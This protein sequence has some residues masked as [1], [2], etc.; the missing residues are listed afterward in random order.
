MEFSTKDR[1]IDR[2]SL[3]CVCCVMDWCLVVQGCHKTNLNGGYLG[4]LG[5]TRDWK[6]VVWDGF[7]FG[8][9]LKFT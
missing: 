8:I 1:D 5:Q 4:D 2:D 7:R 6:G 9:S 3:N